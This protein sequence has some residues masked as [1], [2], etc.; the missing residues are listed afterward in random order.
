MRLHL[1]THMEATES[2]KGEYVALG[3]SGTSRATYDES[4]RKDKGWWIE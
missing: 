3:F 1:Q 4:L 2:L